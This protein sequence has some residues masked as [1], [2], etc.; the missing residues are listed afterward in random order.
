[1]M[2]RY[3]LRNAGRS[4]WSRP[5]VGRATWENGMITP[6]AM[7]STVRQAVRYTP[8]ADGADRPPD[9]DVL[10]PDQGDEEAAG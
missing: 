2:R 9:D 1:M 6:C 5:R 3:A 7:S 10:H 8:T 4:S